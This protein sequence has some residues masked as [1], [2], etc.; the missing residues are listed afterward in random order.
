MTPTSDKRFSHCNVIDITHI[1]TVAPSPL[2]SDASLNYG[3][4]V[5]IISGGA[6]FAA[7]QR[8]WPPVR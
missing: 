6:T 4:A 8:L 5:D 3:P 2:W 1:K 7:L